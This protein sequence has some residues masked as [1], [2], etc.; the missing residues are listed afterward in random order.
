MS[1]DPTKTK[2]IDPEIVK[3]DEHAADEVIHVPKGSSKARFIMTFLLV[4]MVLTTFT[5]SSEVLNVLSG[6]DRTLSSYAVWTSPNGQKRTV[7]NKQF[8][9]EMRALAPLIDM[10][11]PSQ[12]REQTEDSV[13]AFLAFED[14]ARETGIQITDGEVAQWIQQNLGANYGQVLA[15]FRLTPKEY[16]QTLRRV[17]SVDRYRQLIAMPRGIADPKAVETAWKGRHQEYMFDYVEVPVATAVEEARTLAPKGDELKAWFDALSE[18]EKATYKTKPTVSAELVA[19]SL[20]GVPNT[21]ALFAKYP[22]AAGVDAEAEARDYH[23]G[24]GYVRFPM[25]PTPGS[26]VNSQPFDSVKERA[27]IEAPIY[28]ALMAWVA[29]MAKREQAGEVVDVTAEAT[30]LGLSSR[31]QG[32]ARTYEGWKEAGISF[33]GR[34]TLGRLFPPTDEDLVNS[35]G[36]M[37]AAIQV[38]EK[39]FVFGRV[40]TATPA[41]LPEFADIQDRVTQAWADKKAKELALARLEKVRDAFGTR[42]DPTDVN[43]PPFLPTADEAKFKEAVKAAGYDVRRRDWMERNAPPPADETAGDLY[44]RTNPSLYTQKENTVLK[45]E[46]NRE[47]TTAFLVRVGGLRDADVSKMSPADLDQLTR[48]QTFRDQLMFV[49]VESGSREFLQKHFG[50]DLFSWHPENLKKE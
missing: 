9:E 44:V 12:S 16:E 18:P 31:R 13:A 1:Q 26:N 48:E 20:D 15:R 25:T 14:A 23:A 3:G 45:A 19:L 33:V 30:A 11:F 29:D 22:R 35:A 2:P 41:R 50:M 34:I 37:F 42:P 24:F 46:L 21:D 10:V 40:L 38:D 6:K 32:D 43:A 7:S 4:I 17:L 47:G 8:G 36:K 28:N 27:L 39:A 49:R 5:V